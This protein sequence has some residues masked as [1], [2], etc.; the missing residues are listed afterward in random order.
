MD[1]QVKTVSYEYSQQ[2]ELDSVAVKFQRMDG[3]AFFTMNL[4]YVDGME[5]PDKAVGK[6]LAVM[7]DKV[8]EGD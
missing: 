3:G 1:Y 6:A 2:G 7:L 5:T 8:G 4:P